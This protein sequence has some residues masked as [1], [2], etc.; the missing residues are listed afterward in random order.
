MQWD[1]T[2]HLCVIIQTEMYKARFPIAFVRCLDDNG[3]YRIRSFLG[4]EDDTT[5]VSGNK[6]NKYNRNRHNTTNL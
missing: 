1:T 3:I 5:Y 2:S 4:Q 6:L